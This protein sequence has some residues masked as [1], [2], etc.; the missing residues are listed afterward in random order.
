MLT[1]QSHSDI[2]DHAGTNP[3][4]VRRGLG[5]LC[6][7]GLLTSERGPSGGWRLVWRSHDITLADIYVRL[8]KAWSRPVW[9]LNRIPARLSGIWKHR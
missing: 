2:A 3:V 8:E 5:E 1:Q 6:K 7:A 4:V 9:T